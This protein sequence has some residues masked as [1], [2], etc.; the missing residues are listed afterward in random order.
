MIYSKSLYHIYKMYL[1]GFKVYKGNIMQSIK[2]YFDDIEEK[3]TCEWI[4]K[5]IL[6]K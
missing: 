1:R 5:H 6:G 4:E 3:K 2:K